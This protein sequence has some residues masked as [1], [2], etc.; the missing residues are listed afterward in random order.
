[1]DIQRTEQELSR[2][3]STLRKKHGARADDVLAL[4]VLKSGKP[5]AVGSAAYRLLDGLAQRAGLDGGGDATQKL[6]AYFQ[7]NPLPPELSQDVTQSLQA[8]VTRLK[9]PEAQAGIQQLLG[10][11]AAN[12]PVGGSAH[13]A[14]SLQSLR[15]KTLKDAKPARRK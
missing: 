15:M 3:F 7:K 10:V 2:L 5:P 12:K 4:I 8:L 13:S 1:V 9:T 11:K 14:G 6:A